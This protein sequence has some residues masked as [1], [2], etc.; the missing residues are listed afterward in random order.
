MI[1]LKLPAI[2]KSDGRREA[3]DAVSYTHLDVYRDRGRAANG[4]AELTDYSACAAK[5]PLSLIHI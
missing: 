3:F 2:I 1:E 5:L 4:E